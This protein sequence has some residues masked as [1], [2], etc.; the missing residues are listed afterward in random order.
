MLA[1]EQRLDR[2]ERKVLVGADVAGHDGFVRVAHE[3]THPVDRRGGRRVASGADGGQVAAGQ[4]QLGAVVGRVAVHRTDTLHSS[5]PAS[6][7]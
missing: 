2:G 7:P 6:L 4:H 3:L 5:R 1:G